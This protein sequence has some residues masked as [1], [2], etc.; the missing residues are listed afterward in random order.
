MKLY[1]Y[2]AIFFTAVSLFTWVWS[3]RFEAGANFVKAQMAVKLKKAVIKV[4]KEE[5]DKQDKVN[6]IANKQYNK[7]SNINS[8]LNDD[9]DKLRKRSTRTSLSNSA[10]SIC[11]GAT[12]E[13]LSSED[14]G[15]LTREAARADKIRAALET[16]Y[17]YADSIDQ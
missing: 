2:A 11:K 6:E 9:L 7:I 5:Q 4:R 12:G 1:V 10:K 8:K 3:D 16:C 13:Y 15:F 17:T 14:S